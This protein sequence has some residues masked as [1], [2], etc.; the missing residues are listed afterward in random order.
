LP[1]ETWPVLIFI[2]LPQVA[3]IHTQMYVSTTTGGPGTV[4]PP[5]AQPGTVRVI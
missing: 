4:R 2:L 1:F 3:V 5:P